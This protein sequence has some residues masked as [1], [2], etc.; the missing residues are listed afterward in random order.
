MDE[1]LRTN[2][3]NW[4]ERTPV[5]AASDDYDVAGFRA[6]RVTLNALERREVGDVDGKTLL[7]LQCHFGLDTMSWERLGAVVTGVDFSDAAIALAKALRDETGSRARFI[8]SDV[9]A[10]SDVLDERFDIVFTSYGV[11]CW[12]PDLDGWARTI[13]R[14]LKP[15]GV[16]YIAEHH[17]MLTALEQSAESG[18]MVPTYDYFHSQ[19][20]LE[21]G[22][23]SYAGD[24]PIQSPV[25]EWS[26]SLGEIVTALIDA[27]LRI[28]FLREFAFC[29]YRAHPTM[30]RG[31]DGLW[32][33]PERNDAIPQMF[34]LRASA[35]DFSE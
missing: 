3:V 30:E 26:H 11:L 12:L 6:G 9:Y 2:R 34:S 14:R 25:Y 23:P 20:R 19:V 21:G 35:A 18:E 33:F 8:L 13:A 29:G 28:E 16:F 5:H 24:A 22:A 7:H 27:G 15:G 10:L 31:A 4:N 32:R 17:P 1:R